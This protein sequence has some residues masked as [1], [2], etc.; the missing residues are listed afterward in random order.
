[1]RVE[2]NKDVPVSAFQNRDGSNSS[3][4][5]NLQGIGTSSCNGKNG[6][7]RKANKNCKVSETISGANVNGQRL[8]EQRRKIAHKQALKVLAD[9]L[10]SEKNID[11]QMEK[12]SDEIHTCQDKIA[13][14]TDRIEADN[15]RID[16]LKEKYDDNSENNERLSKEI[17][18]LR[19][20]IKNDTKTIRDLKETQVR[21]SFNYTEILKVRADS[22]D[23]R[24]AQ[25]ASER[26]MKTGIRE[27]V[28]LLADEA[29]SHMDEVEKEKEKE[30]KKQAEEKKEEKKEEADKLEREARMQEMIENIK[31]HAEIG[32]TTTSDIKRAYARKERM[33]AAEFDVPEGAKPM[34]VDTSYL[35]ESQGNIQSEITNIMNGLKLLDIDIRGCVI[36][37]TV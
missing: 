26:I 9:A 34:H 1:M 31:E 23:M 25:K 21:S 22:N 24:E 20:E 2:R 14:L 30:A 32:E 15:K 8:V 36:D 3:D 4:V 12:L 18:E 5:S 17:S 19:K 7:R 28:V 35:D 33:E 6:A 16:E 37:D 10:K 11:S 29:V 13:F 27:E